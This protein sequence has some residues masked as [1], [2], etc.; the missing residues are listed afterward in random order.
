MKQ[1]NKYWKIIIIFRVTIRVN[2]HSPLTSFIL[3]N[4][5]CNNFILLA[6]VDEVVDDKWVLIIRWSSFINWSYCFIN[7]Q[8]F[9]TF[10]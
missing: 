6:T 3:H 4:I 1:L 5:A 7:I 9:F 10:E 2:S 8:K